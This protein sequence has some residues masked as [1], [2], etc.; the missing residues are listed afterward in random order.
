VSTAHC[1]RSMALLWPKLV[2]ARSHMEPG[3]VDARSGIA[4]A[5]T[6]VDDRT[7]V[8]KMLDFKGDVL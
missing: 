7:K 5:V 8:S 1:C 4:V 3:A 6:S 2:D